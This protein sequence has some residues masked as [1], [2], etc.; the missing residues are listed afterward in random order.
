MKRLDELGISPAPWKAH[1]DEDFDSN[2]EVRGK[3]NELILCD[4]PHVDARLI[5]AAPDL[6]ECLHEAVCN[7]CRDRI[8]WDR[9]RNECLRKDD[10]A[11][12]SCPGKRWRKALEK[13]GGA[14]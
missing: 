2:D 10:E 14:E 6:Y 1:T 9:Y 13:A 7:Y 11:L 3:N 4:A 8:C 5:A 12:S